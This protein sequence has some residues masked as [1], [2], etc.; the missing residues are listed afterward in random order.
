MTLNVLGISGSPVANSNTDRAVK[1]VLK[2][3]G[4]KHEFIKLS[5]LHIRPCLACKRCVKDNVCKEEDDF[6]WLSKKVTDAD[7]LVIGAYTPYGSIDA[8]TKSFL[9]RLWSLRHVNNLLKG[10]PVIIVVSRLYP[11][12][13]ENYV[14]RVTGLSALLQSLLLPS[15]KVS[16][17]LARELALDRMEVIGQVTIRGNVPCLTCGRGDDCEMSGVKS[18]HGKNAKASANNC[19]RVEDQKDV[20]NK[21]QSFGKI[22]GNRLAGNANQ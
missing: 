11:K 19:S 22:L 12:S 2:A 9:E 13:L 1:A 4:L 16:K 17:M 14:L 7:A 15:Y 20:W 18:L 6:G 3:T 5:D 10:K 8:F 21:L